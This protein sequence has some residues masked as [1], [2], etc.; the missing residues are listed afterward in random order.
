MAA[1]STALHIQVPAMPQPASER[2]SNGVSTP[3]LRLP[4][5]VGEFKDRR[6]RRRVALQPMYTTASIRALSRK[7]ALSMV[8][9]STSVKMA[10]SSRWMIW[11]ASAKP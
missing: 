6:R 1:T 9:S 10:S 7:M 5:A 3:S 4:M 2:R 8:M 11:S